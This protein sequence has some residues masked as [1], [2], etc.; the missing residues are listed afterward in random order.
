MFQANNF[1]PNAK[2]SS[3]PKV[4]NPG[5]HIARVV[6]VYLDEPAYQAGKGTYFV[7]IL[8]EGQKQEEGFEGIAIDKNN[9]AMGRYQGQI[10][11][12]KS[13]RFPYS[14]YD[15]K[16]TDGSVVTITRDEQIFR[17]LMNL[18]MQLNV[19]ESVQ[20]D[21]VTGANIEE[22]VENVKP[23]LINKWAFF[24]IA[25]QEYFTEGY[26]KPNYRLFFPKNDNKNFPFS[27]LKDQNGVVQ[28]FMKFDDTKHIVA[29]KKEQVPAESV[30]SFAPAQPSEIDLFGSVP[31]TG[32]AEPQVAPQ[33]GSF[34]EFAQQEQ[35]EG[36]ELKLPF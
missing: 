30:D 11:T 20:N 4:L 17:F 27:A 13:G 9:P 24:T 32:N 26:E 15:F 29:A 6:N 23:Y 28:N 7:N 10:A 33:N 5:S 2:G 12:V 34:A 25:G 1:N 19:L 21:G 8:L 36:S 22:F 35:S 14:T 3:I 18:C 16:R 31:N